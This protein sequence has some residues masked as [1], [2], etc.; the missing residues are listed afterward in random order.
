[1]IIFAHRQTHNQT[2]SN[3]KTEATFYPLWSVDSR[4]AGQLQNIDHAHR[5]RQSGQ[6]CI[7]KPIII[8][9]VINVLRH[10]RLVGGEHFCNLKLKKNNW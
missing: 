4:G 10:N 5:D 1:M 7:N 3:S 6:G 8:S 9:I 2:K